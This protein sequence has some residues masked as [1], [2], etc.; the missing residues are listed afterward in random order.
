MGVR[1]R[2]DVRGSAVAARGA[3][4]TRGAGPARLRASL[5]GNLSPGL[6]PRPVV[7]LLPRVLSAPALTRDFVA[8]A[9]LVCENALILPHR[10]GSV[11]SARPAPVEPLREN[12]TED[13]M[14]RGL[15]V[16]Q[17]HVNWT[18]VGL[19]WPKHNCGR[20]LPS[21]DAPKPVCSNLL[22]LNAKLCPSKVCERPAQALTLG[23]G[24]D[25]RSLAGLKHLFKVFSF[26]A[27]SS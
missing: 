3:G 18:H 6:L 11:G 25:R 16:C 4:P 13:R 12:W 23:S 21:H 26:A 27:A 19:N 9:A 8:S 2:S 7:S 24:R 20:L 22:R 10:R 14:K 17:K 5:S 1:Q 15:K